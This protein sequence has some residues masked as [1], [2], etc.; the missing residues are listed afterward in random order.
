MALRRKSKKKRRYL[1]FS[2]LAGQLAK[3]GKVSDPKA[4]AAAIGRKKYGAK[5]MGALSAAGRR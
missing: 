4:V 2:K 3:K 5:G 1:G